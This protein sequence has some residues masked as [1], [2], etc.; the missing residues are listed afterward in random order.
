M[1]G[2]IMLSHK[3]KHRG[4]FLGGEFLDERHQK[5]EFGFVL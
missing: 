3:H 5:M 4:L 1:D 2:R